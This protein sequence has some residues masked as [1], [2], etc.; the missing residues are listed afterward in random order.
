L[1]VVLE[2]VNVTKEVQSTHND[3]GVLRQTF[4]FGRRISVGARLKF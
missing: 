1:S 4:D 3:N 2:A